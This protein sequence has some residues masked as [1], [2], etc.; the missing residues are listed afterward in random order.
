M[1]YSVNNSVLWDAIICNSVDIYENFVGISFNII[2]DEQSFL[3]FEKKKKLSMITCRHRLPY[4][5]YVWI[6]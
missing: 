1:G 4:L 2:R 6:E 3:S 5:F